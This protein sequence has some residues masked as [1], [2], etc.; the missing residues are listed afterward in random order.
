[1]QG[2]IQ[3]VIV[4]TGGVGFF[5]LALSGKLDGQLQYLGQQDFGGTKADAIEW[6]ASFGPMKLYFDPAT[7]QLIGS[8]FRQVS[9]QGTAEVEQ[10]WSGFKAFEGIQLPT[11]VVVMRDGTKYS[12][13]TSQEVKLNPAFDPSVF[14]KPKAAAN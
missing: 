12:E 3:R 10:H 13:T 9:Q 1:M 5:Q 4:M 2:D 6:K 11:S 14:A 8:H 7:H